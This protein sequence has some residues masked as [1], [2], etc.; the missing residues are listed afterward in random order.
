MNKHKLK[1]RFFLIIFLSGVLNFLIFFIWISI[2]FSPIIPQLQF[3]KNEAI[4]NEIDNKYLNEK[5]F[6]YDLNEFEK[7]LSLIHI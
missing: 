7:N 2:R 3:I 6:F 4:I 5:K 1:H